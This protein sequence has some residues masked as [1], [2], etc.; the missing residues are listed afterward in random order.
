MTRES[1]WRWISPEASVTSLLVEAATRAPGAPALHF[2]GKQTSYAAFFDQVRRLARSFQN[3]G[4]GP[5]ERLAVLLPNCPQL[6]AAYH[7]ILSLGGV[8]VLLNP[9]LQSPG[10]R[11]SAQGFGQ[12][13]PGGPGPPPPQGGGRGP[14]G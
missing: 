1:P 5:G 14:G 2:F 6:A 12:P 3:L 10:N 7:A 11:P 9:L 4:L 8:A 13:Q